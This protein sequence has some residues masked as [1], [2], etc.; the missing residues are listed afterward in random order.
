MKTKKII[1]RVNLK[2]KKMT[3]ITKLGTKQGY[4]YAFCR[5]LN[6]RILQTQCINF[7]KWTNST[8]KK[9][10]IITTHEL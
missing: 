9:T 10:L 2:K 6:K 7:I 8:K 3:Q 1:E 4:H 5:H